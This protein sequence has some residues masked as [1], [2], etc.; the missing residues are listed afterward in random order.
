TRALGSKTVILQ[1]TNGNNALVFAPSTATLTIVD[2]ERL[3]GQFQFT[4][5]NYVVSEADGF[6]PVTI[7]R[8]N[9]QAGQVSVAFSTQPG[10]A[11]AGYKYSP[12]NGVLS[13][14][15][16][17]LSKTFTVRIFQEGQVEGNQTFGLILS[18]AT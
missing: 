15:D 2:V 7:V 14:S 4:Q 1:L 13:F 17:E 12:T 11:I 10:T 3:P 8:T 6:M 9:G 18:N 5:T 16:G